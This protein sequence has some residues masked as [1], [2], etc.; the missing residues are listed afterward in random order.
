MS[1]R[2]LYWIAAILIVIVA[3]VVGLLFFVKR[4]VED[5]G[6]TAR[7]RI[8]KALQD[9]FDA[10][11][12]LGSVQ[13]SL[14]PR[15]MATLEDLRIRHKGWPADHPLIY[16]RKAVAE[17]DYDTVMARR[18]HVDLVRLEGLQIH[19]P[20]KGRSAGIE[21]KQD[22]V[23]VESSAPGHDTTRFRYVIDTIIA[24]GAL[25]EIE[26]KVQGKKPLDFDI[27]KLTLH[28]VG[29][30]QPM[31]FNA[32][33]TNAKPPGVIQTTGK[34]GPW[35]R[36]DPR[37]TAVSGNYTFRNANLDVF[38]G[39]SGTLSSEGAYHGVLQHIEVDGKTDTPDFALKRGGEPVDL[40]TTFHSIVNGSD[41][42]TILD[43]VRARFLH[44]EFICKGGVVHYPG[45]D[46]KTVTLNAVAPHARMEDIL[47]L[48]M[49]NDKPILTGGVNFR[50]KILI[51]PG[52]ED[53]IDKLRL[54][55]RFAISS[56][57]FTSPEVEHRLQTLSD[58]ARGI[59]KDEEAE[60][61]PQRVASN[62]RG[63]FKLNNGVTSFSELSFSVPGAAIRLVG[64]YSLRSGAI[65][66]NGQFRMQA[67]LSDTQSG[68]KHWLLK[69]FDTFFEKEGAGFELPI[70]IQGTREHP[71]I[72]AEVFHHRFTIH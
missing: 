30:G 28:S 45:Q 44:S 42:D 15:P 65:D 57:Q 21:K 37:A 26:P 55:G 25:L 72:G 62:F 63:I 71:E 61:P 38:K 52:H 35:Q 32:A 5:Y 53:V 46:G 48:V 18:N 10:D 24:D 68:I 11:V 43:P 67:T 70:T 50:S 40:V 8:I 31:T 60:Q 9:R 41:G 7:E 27:A 16:I 13:I 49:G 1:K 6:P 33:L 2:V 4:K 23:E 66:M 36:D 17:T 51:P 29:V 3:V 59:S 22:G 19:L 14:T 34:F 39:I 56:A 69:P 12:D 64:N 58:R 47:R 54:D 20:P